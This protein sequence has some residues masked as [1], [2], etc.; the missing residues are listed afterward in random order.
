ML[1]V[2]HIKQYVKA[3]KLIIAVSIYVQ[4][5]KGKPGFLSQI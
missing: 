3:S 2:L 4:I 5:I 1:F